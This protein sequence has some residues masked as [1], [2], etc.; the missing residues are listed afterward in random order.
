M[1]ARVIGQHK[2]RYVLTTGGGELLASL[3]GRLRHES[4]GSADLPAVGDLVT[5]SI[6]GS[7][8]A[9]V[10]AV[11]PRRSVLRRRDT[12][13]HDG[14]I[15][16]ANVDDAF[17]VVP[18]HRDVTP[19]QGRIQ[20]YAALV[21]DSGAVPV[22][23]LTKADLCP[24]LAAQVARASRAAPGVEV[25]VTSSLT[26]DGVAEVARRLASG[27]TG[28]L[29]GPSGAGK[30]SLI[31]A[32]TGATLE[33]REIGGLGEGRH[34]SVRR[35]LVPLPGGGAVIDTPG[36]REVDAWLSDAAVA[37]AY[38]DVAALAR[39]CRFRDCT[40]LEEPGCAVRAGV[41]SGQLDPLRL[42]GMRALQAA[43]ERM[44]KTALE[45]RRRHRDTGRASQRE[46]KARSKDGQRPDA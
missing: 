23:L 12:G 46:A 17:I 27:R 11:L 6:G 13:A 15:L 16:A 4:R 41:L 24:D 25:I 30:S 14:Q 3:A 34:A 1:T 21:H 20:Q 29:L 22:L 33:T 37:E 7:P 39:G 45:L 36:L 28:V 26:G 18:L 32:L 31:N 9:V 35:E 43:S 44:R 40:H 10:H 19:L 8:A 2:G 38:P 42:E 5:V